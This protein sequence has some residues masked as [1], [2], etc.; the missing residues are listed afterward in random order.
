MS[1]TTTTPESEH[2]ATGLAAALAG[3]HEAVRWEGARDARTI[4]VEAPEA[5]PRRVRDITLCARLAARALADAEDR[6]NLGAEAQTT[7]EIAHAGDSERPGR[8]LGVVGSRWHPHA[9]D[10]EA[11]ERAERASADETWAVMQALN[12]TIK[13]FRPLESPAGADSAPLYAVGALSGGRVRAVSAFEVDAGEAAQAG[14]RHIARSAKVKPGTRR[15]SNGGA[16]RGR[17]GREGR[18]R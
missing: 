12:A 7:I 6:E 2:T 11:I 3:A 10:E 17:R 13:S 4:V 1:G 18:R 5:P 14:L 9:E 15:G 16:R 8:W